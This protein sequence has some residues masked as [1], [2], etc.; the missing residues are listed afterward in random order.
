MIAHLITS[1]LIAYLM[2]SLVNS[3]L[4]LLFI[5]AYFF[6]SSVNSY[7]ISSSVTECLI[8]KF[9]IAHFILSLHW[10]LYIFYSCLEVANLIILMGNKYLITQVSY[11]LFDLH[12]VI[13]SL[14]I[15]VYTYIS[16]INK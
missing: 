4:I 5:V 1:L 14:I 2:T 10:E 8:T 15:A 13:A 12:I 16:N 6:T 11:C 7:Q 9:V 3:Y